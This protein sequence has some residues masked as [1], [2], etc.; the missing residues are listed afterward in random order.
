VPS[1][2]QAAPDGLTLP[3]LLDIPLRNSPAT[4]AQ[5]VALLAFIERCKECG[6]AVHDVGS[7]LAPPAPDRGGS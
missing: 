7:A 1:D 6:Q 3:Q 2:I 5:S 4:R